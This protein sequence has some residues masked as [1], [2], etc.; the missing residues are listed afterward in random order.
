MGIK[1]GNNNQDF[2]Y[3][4]EN[5]KNAWDIVLPSY[6]QTELKIR[7][8]NRDFVQNYSLVKKFRI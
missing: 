6:E 2:I 4:R 7:G 3:F 5:T 1:H 8:R